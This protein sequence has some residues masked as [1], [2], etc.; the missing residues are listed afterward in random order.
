MKHD[1]IEQPSLAFKETI[2]FMGQM[3]ENYMILIDSQKP[4]P[5]SI[6]STAMQKQQGEDGRFEL[7]GLLGSRASSQEKSNRVAELIKEMVAVGATVS[8]VQ[9]HVEEESVMIRVTS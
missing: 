6:P 7:F 1:R 9:I 8:D 2:N 4:L 5:T 3:G